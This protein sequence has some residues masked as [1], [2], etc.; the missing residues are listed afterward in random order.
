MSFGTWSVR[1]LYRQGSF[2]A[3]AREL[4]R[5]KLDLVV[6]QDVRWSREGTVRAGLI[7]YSTEKETKMITWEQYFCT[8]QNSISS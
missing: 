8:Q 7:I 1:R 4:T 6:V 5:Y 3:A 2:T